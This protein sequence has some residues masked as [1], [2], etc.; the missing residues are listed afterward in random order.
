VRRRVGED[1][2][3]SL[4]LSIEEFIKGGYTVEEMQTILPDFVQAGVDIIHASI[5]THG[6][7][8]GITSAPAEYEPGFNT[9][10]AK[11]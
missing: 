11:R 5:G 4:R 9:W 3:I 2:P 6:S 8:A 1:F 10:R 7:P